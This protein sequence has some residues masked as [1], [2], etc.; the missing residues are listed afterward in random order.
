MRYFAYGSN[1]WTPR[2]RERVPSCQFVAVARLVRHKLCFHKRSI[3]ESSKC[4]AFETGSDG[5]L[6]W[7]VVFDVPSSEKTR[8][9]RAEGLGNG[10]DEKTVNVT[11]RS[12]DRLDAITYYAETSAIRD[13]MSPY[14]W[15]K[16]LVLNGAKEHELPADYIASS[17]ETVAALED[18]DKARDKQNRL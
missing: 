2:L 8:L 1:M 15:Y 9:D 3:D 16:D 14:T 17:I 6:V 7:G 12:G 13:S 10:Y 4:D 5:D 11:T 18:P